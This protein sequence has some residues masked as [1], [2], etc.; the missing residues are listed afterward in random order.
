MIKISLTQGKF[1]L[2]DD[3]DFTL[4]N[5][6]KW[7][8][9]NNSGYTFYAIHRYQDK[10]TKK[11]IYIKMHRL[12]MNPQDNEE[13]DHI[14]SDGLNNQKF[15]LRICTSQQNNM[16]R[17]KL[18]SCSSKFK[19][20]YWKKQYKKWCSRIKINNK[21][22]HLGYFDNEIEAAKTYDAAARKYFGEFARLNFSDE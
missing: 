6:Y 12:I 22:K 14:D 5:S 7:Y 20:V 13:I 11:S 9:Q 21:F 10:Q 16:N 17:K 18:K 15:N 4:I 19:G 3:K 1:A 8:A 2:I